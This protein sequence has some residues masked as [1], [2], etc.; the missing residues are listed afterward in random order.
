MRK[1]ILNIATS[2]DGYIAREDGGFDWI[3]GCGNNR[4]NTKINFDFDLFLDS[5]DIVIMG[6]KAYEDTGIDHI[7]G[8]E[9]KRIIVLTRKNYEY[10]CNVEFFSGDIIGLIKELKQ[11]EGGN[12]WIYGG[13][14][15]A[16]IFIKENI[17]DEYI[18]GIIPIILGK[19][20]P[21]FIGKNPE[22]K[23][24]LEENFIEDGIIINRYVKK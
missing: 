14:I 8:Y 23:M 17:I 1:T 11:E 10:H 3:M 16:D 24:K 22:I 19:G 21:L 13:G 20:K 9:K 15:I 7:K 5:I 12:I 18:I 2:I 6:S 4:I